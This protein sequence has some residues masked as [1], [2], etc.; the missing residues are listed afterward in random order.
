MALDNL[1]DRLTMIFKGLGRA[2]L[3]IVQS[4]GPRGKK[5]D[6]RA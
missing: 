2:H 5:N 6:Q 4:A 1:D 3:C